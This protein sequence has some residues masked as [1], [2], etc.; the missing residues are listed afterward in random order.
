MKM[1][2]KSYFSILFSCH[3]FI[4]LYMNNI[5]LTVVCQSMRFFFKQEP[6]KFVCF[7]SSKLIE[8]EEEI[9]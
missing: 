5:V 9:F 3:L 8:E 1:I 4:Y 2:F 6:K 7:S